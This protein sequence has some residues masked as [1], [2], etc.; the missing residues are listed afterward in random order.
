MTGI[1]D[2]RESLL[3]RIRDP[4]DRDAWTEFVAIYQPLIHRVARR[5][6]L[7]EADTQN[8]TQEVLQKIERQAGE[9]EPGQSTG[10]FRRWL[11]V[12]ARNAAVDAI[13]RMRPDAASGGSSVR[14]ALQS[15]PA[16]VEDSV[17]EFRRA[18]ERQAFRWA[19]QRIHDEFAED[20][21]D[22][23]W[24]TMVDGEACGDVA[25][26]LRRSV[27]SVHTARSRV[28]QRLKQELEHFDWN[29]AA[30]ESEPAEDQS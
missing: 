10:S 25:K 27:R 14:H 16:P 13:R 26:R 19:A 22:A 4:R 7:Q 18:L 2:T 11:A 12:V 17:A 23:I 30:D 28:M 21:W 1:P 24:R 3:L 20:T 9:W 6:G 8:L 5:H 29:L 15:V